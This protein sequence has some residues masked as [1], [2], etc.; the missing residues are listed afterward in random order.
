MNRDK[1]ARISESLRQYRRAELLDFEEELGQQP[2]DK[3]YVDPLPNNA[4]LKS[5][6]SSN[7]TFLLGRKGT[8]KSTVF[9]KAQCDFRKRKDVL[10]TYIDVKSL[11]ETI[12]SSEIPAC[13]MDIKDINLG[14]YKTHIIRKKFLGTI[15]SALLKEI[16]DVCGKMSIWDKWTSRGRSLDDL[17][18]S[19]KSLQKEVAN[20]VLKIDELP[21]L[22]KIT[23]SY[24]N[25][26]Q[27]ETSQTTDMGASAGIVTKNPAIGVQATQSDFDKTLDDKQIYDEYSDV[28]L[29]SFPFDQIISEIK[30]LITDCGLKRV[31]LFFDDFSELNYLDQRLF[32]D[33][34]LSPLNNSS[35]EIIKLK[36]AGYPGRV[37]Y[38]RIDPN[39]VDTICLDFSSIYEATEV[40]TMEKS[41]IDYAT[42]LLTTRFDAFNEKIAEYFDPKTPFD[43]HMRLI[44]ETTFNV[45]R[46]MGILLHTCYLDSISKNLPI[47]TSALRLASR[48]HY[49]NTI[50]Q[51][52][53]R[54]NRYALEPFENKLDRTNQHELLQCIIQEMV[55]VRRKIS[56]GSLKGTFFDGL[57]N[58]P[59]SHFII[60]PILCDVLQSLESNFLL[61][62]YKDTRDKE[63]KTACVYAL[64]YGLTESERLA[65]GYPP[66][67]KYR[68][69]FQQRCFDFSSYIRLFLSKNKT[70]KCNTCGK[71]YS[72]DQSSSFELYRWQCPE[73]KEGICSIENIG[74]KYKI[75]F[76]TLDKELM[77]EKVELDILN[78]LVSENK[79][80]RAREISS[81]MDVTYQLVGKRTE[82]LRELGLVDKN[83]G[84][85]NQTR[86]VITKKARELYFK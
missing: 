3:L 52:F 7:T 57:T 62:K 32:V 13:T 63:G 46:L 80:M 51:Y 17:K 27:K 8:G 76:A 78:T 42:R 15:L 77:V 28:V 26:H 50:I 53:D 19:L 36:I 56:D 82:K 5:V 1:F 23:R 49:E 86:S 64:Y 83:L 12:D 9:A 54:M 34:V 20:T 14:V 31:V 18:A 38:G 4:V 33:V 45:P 73:C 11:C 67:R 30:T 10:T 47:T 16:D 69:Y 43:Q 25:R 58:P 2:V 84:K 70:I 68:A 21:I 71:C 6:L 35:N 44:F 41:A 72:L 48:K 24:T 66:E 75:E 59:T 61:S 65:W 60:N 40:Q 85:D 29:R 81:L 55:T 37:Y 22:Q 79:A 74:D 39:K